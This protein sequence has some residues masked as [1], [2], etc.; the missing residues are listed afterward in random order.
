M[1]FYKHIK[2]GLVMSEEMCLNHMKFIM[3]VIGNLRNETPWEMLQR[4]V[5]DKHYEIV[6]NFNKEIEK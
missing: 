5:K 6:K 3:Q 1:P 4:R 2:S